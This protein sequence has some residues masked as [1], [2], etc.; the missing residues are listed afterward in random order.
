MLQVIHSKD[1][2]HLMRS[3]FIDAVLVFLPGSDSKQNSVKMQTL[4]MAAAHALRGRE[5]QHAR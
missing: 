2:I 1:D 4:G 3:G 5:S